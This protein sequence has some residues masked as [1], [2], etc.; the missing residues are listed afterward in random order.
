V[1][2]EVGLAGVL[3]PPFAGTH[4]LAGVGHRGGLVEALKERVAHEGAW[5]R[6]VAAYSCVDVAEELAPLRDWYA[7]LQVA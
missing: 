5:R 6:V 4:D 1:S 3:L 7:L 2:R